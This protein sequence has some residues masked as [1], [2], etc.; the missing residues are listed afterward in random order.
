MRALGALLGAIARAGARTPGS[1]RVL[2]AEL[3]ACGMDLKLY[4]VL[5]L[6]WS[7]CAVMATGRFIVTLTW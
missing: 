5:D 1:G 6:D 3:R 2:A 4:P 7:R